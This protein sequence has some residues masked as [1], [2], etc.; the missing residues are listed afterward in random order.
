MGGKWKEHEKA[1]P[2]DCLTTVK[3][4]ALIHIPIVFWF[5][6][7]TK[8]EVIVRKNSNQSARMFYPEPRVNLTAHWSDPKAQVQLY[9]YIWR[10]SRKL[11]TGIKAFKD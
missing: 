6:T 1:I 11:T 2:K 7:K 9:L 10:T 4:F 5:E 8:T 3:G